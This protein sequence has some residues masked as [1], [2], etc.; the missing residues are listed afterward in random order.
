MSSSNVPT[1]G[2]RT[3][4]LSRN[5]DLHLGGTGDLHDERANNTKVFG[6]HS[7]P[8]SMQAPIHSVEFSAIRGPHG[9]IPIRVLYPKSGEERRKYGDAGAL[10]YFHGGGYT[11]G[12][13]DE[14]ENGL[15]IVAEESG[16]QVYAVECRLAPE[17]RFPTQLDEYVAVVEW[18]QGKG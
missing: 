9:T 10:I 17:W 8:S 3:T 15:R 7:L 16:V 6:F 5:P 14:F 1:V 11:V 2:T 12:T 18:V 13:V 4:F